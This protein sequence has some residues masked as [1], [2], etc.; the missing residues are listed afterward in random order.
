VV[1]D[2]LVTFCGR[3][4]GLRAQQFNTSYCGWPSL[5]KSRICVCILH[6]TELWLLAYSQKCISS[7]FPELFSFASDPP[8]SYPLVK[9]FHF[10]PSYKVSS[11]FSLKDSSH[12]KYLLI[13]IFRSVVLVFPMRVGLQLFTF[14]ILRG[15]RANFCIKVANYPTNHTYLLCAHYSPNTFLFAC[16]SM[17]YRFL[18]VVLLD[19]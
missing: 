3:I 13:A 5:F 16:E 19:E 10:R 17:F 18:R 15:Y 14:V 6:N 7:I 12:G 2:D 9:P 1:T 11:R 8:S 4:R